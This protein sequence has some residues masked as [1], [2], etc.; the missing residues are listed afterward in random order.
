MEKKSKKIVNSKIGET[1]FIRL[2]FPSYLTSHSNPQNLR[3]YI[4]NKEMLKRMDK[5]LKW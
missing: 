1:I 4:G 5:I 3:Q 2:R